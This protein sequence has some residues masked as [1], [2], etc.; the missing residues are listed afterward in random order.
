MQMINLLPGEYIGTQR[1]KLFKNILGIGLAIELGITGII[2]LQPL[3]ELNNKEEYLGAIEEKLSNP[4][5]DEVEKMQVQLQNVEADYENWFNRL[6]EI[7]N[8]SFVSGAV[9]DTL[10]GNVP[11][12]VTIDYLQLEKQSIVIKGKTTNTFSARGYISKLQNIYLEADMSFELAEIEEGAKY[13]P[14]SV[15]MIFSEDTKEGEA[16]DKEENVNEE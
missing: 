16:S 7:K 5:F 6:S 15:E 9:L 1:N 11:I 13:S 4:R 14:F 10:L 3:K 2:G 12:G 8:T